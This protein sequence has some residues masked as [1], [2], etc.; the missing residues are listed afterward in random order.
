LSL[1]QQLDS[2]ESDTERA[3]TSGDTECAGTSVD[4]ATAL[5]PTF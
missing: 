1:K 4:T 2:L 5:W 3:G